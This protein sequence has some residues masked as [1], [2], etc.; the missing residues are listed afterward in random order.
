MKELTNRIE[1]CLA[2]LKE[3]P[4]QIRAEREKMDGK[5]AIEGLKTRL[6]GL[7]LEYIADATLAV[8]TG[9]DKPFKMYPN[10]EARENY[11]LKESINDPEYGQLSEEIKRFE[12]QR[13]T[14][15][16]NHEALVKEHSGLISIVDVLGTMLS[17]DITQIQIEDKAYTRIL[18]MEINKLTSRAEI[19]AAKNVGEFENKMDKE[20]EASNEEG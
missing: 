8:T 13:N 14:A 2:R 15:S 9:G 6:K 12:S 7:W 5:A 18:D 1:E 20:Q 11:A 16:M 3:L 4:A 17:L 10:S 19:E